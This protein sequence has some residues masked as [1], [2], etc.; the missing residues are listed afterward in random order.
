[1]VRLDHL[2]LPVGDWQ[3]SRNW[4]RDHLGFEVEF[5]ITSIAIGS[6]RRVIV[7]NSP[8]VKPKLPSPIAAIVLLAG[9]PIAAPAAALI[10]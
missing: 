4:Y 9:R 10:A 2:S 3:K 5:E 6:L 1:M 8:Q 7:S